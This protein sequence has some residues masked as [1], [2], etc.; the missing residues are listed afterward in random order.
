MSTY[1]IV[2]RLVCLDYCLWPYEPPLVPR[3]AL[4]FGYLSSVN[5]GLKGQ[6][7]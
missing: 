7:Q 2:G 4:Y 3:D 6:R 1:A 5:G